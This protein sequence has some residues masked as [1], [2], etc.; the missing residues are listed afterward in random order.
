[1]LDLHVHKIIGYLI[2]RVASF[3][4]PSSFLIHSIQE[5]SI[6]EG[7]IMEIFSCLLDTFLVPSSYFL[8]ISLF[9]LAT[10]FIN[11]FM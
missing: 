8:L 4:Y 6:L 9:L 10:I 11:S 1:M 5:T 7:V 3:L 2:Q